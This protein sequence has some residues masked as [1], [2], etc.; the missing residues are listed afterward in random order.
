MPSIFSDIRRQRK[1]EVTEA[2]DSGCIKEKCSNRH[3]FFRCFPNAV[4]SNNAVRGGRD[5]RDCRRRTPSTY[6]DFHVKHLIGLDRF[7]DSV[8]F[9]NFFH[10]ISQS[11]TNREY[12]TISG[13]S[14]ATTE[15]QNPGHVCWSTRIS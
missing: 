8:Q 9:F 14:S 5:V 6:C 12:V 1:K 15:S 3:G 2:T 11:L 4:V 7:H 13:T 10:L